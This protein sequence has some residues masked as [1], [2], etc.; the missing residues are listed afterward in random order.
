MSGTI[1]ENIAYGVPDAHQQSIVGAAKQASA[2]SF[3]DALPRGYETLVGQRGQLLSGGQRQRIALARALLCNPQI[4]VLDEATNALDSI[5]EGEIHDAFEA[6]RGHCTMVVIAHRLG[7]IRNADYVVVLDQ[8][9]VVEKG[10]PL[11]LLQSQGLLAKMYELQL[12]RTT[13]K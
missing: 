2:H 9:R 4:L 13:V 7:T 6:V 5:T 1:A 3:I 11:D 12:L 8:G 10:R